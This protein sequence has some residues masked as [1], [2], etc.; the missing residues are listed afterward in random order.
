MRTEQVRGSSALIMGGAISALYFAFL[1]YAGARG[2]L[3][4]ATPLAQAVLLIE[5]LKV[6]LLFSIPRLRNGSWHLVYP[7]ATAEVA[8]TPAAY[9]ALAVLHV[10]GS[11]MLVEQFLEVYLASEAVV[12]PA[13]TIFRLV[14]L[15]AK[16]GEAGR[17]LELAVMQFGLLSYVLEVVVFSTNLTTGLEGLGASMIPSAAFLK[18]PSTFT[19]IYAL[20]GTAGAGFYFAM[21]A[22]ASLD[23][24]AS[25]FRTR[26]VILITT[27]TLSAA[28]LALSS[29]LLGDVTLALSAATFFA[30]LSVWWVAHG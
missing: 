28:A 30:V 15:M 4:P 20:I 12:I 6:I 11:G 25:Q 8:L 7:L 9:A 14:S 26:T 16:G 1:Y 17:A 19:P 23:Q 24:E 5:T 22:Y 27:S 18:F 21:L 29:G 3:F 2:L 10:P 13:Y